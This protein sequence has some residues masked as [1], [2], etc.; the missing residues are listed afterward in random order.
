ME[1]IVK[2]AV[3]TNPIKIDDKPIKFSTTA[4]HV[5]ILRSTEGNLPTIMARITAHKRAVGSVLHIGMA[6]NHRGNPH[7]GIRVERLYGIPVLLSGIGALVISQKEED[8]INQHHK[9]ILTGIQRLLPKTPNAVI[10]FLAG[11]LSGTALLHL[12]QLSI[13]GMICRL[14]ENILHQHAI[15]SF[16]SRIQN[17]HS[18]FNQICDQC[19][20]YQLPHPLK[21]LQTP[22]SKT[23]FKDLIKRNM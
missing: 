7:A 13:F 20:L 22:L 10:C 3:N 6:R 9:D 1:N 17:T 16:S 14:T 15:N 18:W 11:S 4:E 12:R 5:G 21:L 2:Y 23:N 19:L 8:L